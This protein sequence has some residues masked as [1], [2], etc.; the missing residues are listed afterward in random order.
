MYKEQVPIS[1]E[2]I[3]EMKADITETQMNLPSII[4]DAGNQLFAFRNLDDIEQIKELI[5][6]ADLKTLEQYTSLPR[7]KLEFLDH[8]ICDKYDSLI[9]ELKNPNLTYERFEEIMKESW[10]LTHFKLSSKI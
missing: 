10:N 4:S 1:K 3:E 6:E 2:D 9:F 7:E 8:G 5:K